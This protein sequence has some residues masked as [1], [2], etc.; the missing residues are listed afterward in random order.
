MGNFIYIMK[1]M[2]YME[3]CSVYGVEETKPF[4]LL[5]PENLETQYEYILSEESV[6]RSP[7]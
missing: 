6:T 2:V 3:Y 1:N 7:I 5:F 4:Y